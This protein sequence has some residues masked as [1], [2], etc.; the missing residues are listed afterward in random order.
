MT[1]LDAY[2][3][4]G[5]EMKD[6]ALK[7][8]A[9]IA[10]I[11]WSEVDDV[12]LVLAAGDEPGEYDHTGRISLIGTD[13]CAGEDRIDVTLAGLNCMWL[14]F[15]RSFP[16]FEDREHS[17]GSKAW[18]LK[19]LARV[20]ASRSAAYMTPVA[21]IR[22]E[23]DKVAYLTDSVEPAWSNFHDL[24]AFAFH[25]RDGA[26]QTSDRGI[27]VDGLKSMNNSHILRGVTMDRLSDFI[28][29]IGD[30]HKVRSSQYSMRGHVSSSCSVDTE[31]ESS[32]DTRVAH[33][34]ASSPGK[35]ADYVPDL[36]R[37]LKEH[38]SLEPLVASRDDKTTALRFGH[39]QSSKS[40]E[41]RAEQIDK[42]L[43]PGRP[44]QPLTEHE[45]E[46][47]DA[48]NRVANELGHYGSDHPTKANCAEGLPSPVPGQVEMPLAQKMA[49]TGGRKFVHN[50]GT[51][52]AKPTRP[53]APTTA[54]GEGENPRVHRRHEAPC[55]PTQ[56]G[57]P[58]SSWEGIKFDKRWRPPLFD[59]MSLP[60]V[61]GGYQNAG[62][63]PTPTGQQRKTAASTPNAPHSPPNVFTE[64]GLNEALARQAQGDLA[65][66]EAH[67]GVPGIPTR[68]PS[69]KPKTPPAHKAN[70]LTLPNASKRREIDDLEYRIH[71][72]AQELLPFAN[73]PSPKLLPPSPG[74]IRVLR[75]GATKG[76]LEDLAECHA[77]LMQRCEYADTRAAYAEDITRRMKLER[78]HYIHRIYETVYEKEKL[79][80]ETAWLR[81][82]LEGLENIVKECARLQVQCN[83]LEANL[84]AE[85]EKRTIAEERCQ[86]WEGHF[87]KA[88]GAGPELFEFL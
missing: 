5:L 25:G 2:N 30:T 59:R 49:E 86:L 56:N 88:I 77:N 31:V 48:K 42:R 40:N 84:K 23:N 18:M 4:S 38:P 33:A 3:R 53:D 83:L 16:G 51:P 50:N 6:T 72:T 24:A 22:G 28:N 41:Q 47:K 26:T 54:H 1:R 80:R 44:S 62:L 74:L 10:S 7:P 52:T 66:E 60:A 19:E 73:Q 55:Q 36:S 13:F 75:D 87:E 82:K 64:R 46:P 85:V 37:L 17:R 34:G 35:P 32:P 57:H 78:Q 14:H 20:Y 39:P 79:L 9:R 76:Y 43:H 68:L 71:Q 45:A 63:E 27:T 65:A 21:A 61:L 12:N 11:P 69:G 67:A 15:T 8:P 29:D 58:V 70:A 81:K